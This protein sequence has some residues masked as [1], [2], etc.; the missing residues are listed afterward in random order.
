MFKYR[1]VDQ[2]VPAMCLNLTVAR[3]RAELPSG[4]AP[5]TRVRHLISRLMRSRKLLVLMRRQCSSGNA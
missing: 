3:L 5:T 4:K 2:G 1:L